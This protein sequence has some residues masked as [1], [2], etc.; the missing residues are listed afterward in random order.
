MDQRQQYLFGLAALIALVAL[1]FWAW[2][3]YEEQQEARFFQKYD[4]TYGRVL[5]YKEDSLGRSYP[6]V[7]FASEDSQ[8]IEL[9]LYGKKPES[10]PIGEPVALYYDLINPGDAGLVQEKRFQIWFL[11]IGSV[12]LLVFSFGI[13]AWQYQKRYQKRQLL[14]HGRRIRAS[15]QSV[16]QDPQ[17]R[18]G[19]RPAYVIHCQWQKNDGHQTTYTFRSDP[20]PEDPSPRL[21][22]E[23]DVYI[24]FNNPE[25]YWVD[26]SSLV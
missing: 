5:T 15:V 20:L 11:R 6:I 1:G 2:A 21:K 13:F 14:Q 16:G 25:K 24:D 18:M 7:I 23:L 3:T 10:Y 12:A 17:I 8:R 26:I 22:P 4:R 9:P 19:G